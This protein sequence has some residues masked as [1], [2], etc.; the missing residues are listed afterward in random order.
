MLP[1][2]DAALLASQPKFEALYRDLCCNKLNRNGTS[3]PDARTLKEREALQD[4]VS[5]L[6][7]TVKILLLLEVLSL[8]GAVGQSIPMLDKCLQL[9]TVC[10]PQNNCE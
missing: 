4:E 10:T 9:F 8:I 2:A 5:E 1:P 3:K 7:C 6:V